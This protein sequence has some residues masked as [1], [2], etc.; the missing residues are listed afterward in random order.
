MEVAIGMFF[1]PVIALWAATGQLSWWWLIAPVVSIVGGLTGLFAER[2][3]SSA[4]ATDG[5]QP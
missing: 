5:S 4:A 1:G 2:R 3:R